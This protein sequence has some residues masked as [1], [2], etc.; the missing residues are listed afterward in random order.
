MQMNK[1]YKTVDLQYSIFVM[2]LIAILVFS[3]GSEFGDYTATNRERTMA[4]KLGYAHYDVS[5][6]GYTNFIWNNET[7]THNTIP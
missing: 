4:V 7:N 5:P 6:N 2:I 1:I 3:I